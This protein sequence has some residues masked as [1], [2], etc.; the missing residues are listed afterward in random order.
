ME[1]KTKDSLSRWREEGSQIIQDN[2]EVFCKLIAQAKNYT[3]S[4]KYDAGACYA[5]IA[6][7]HALFQHS[8]FFDT[9]S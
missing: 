5:E 2:F 4:G 6:A 7:M 3:Q 1:T 9:I 8:G